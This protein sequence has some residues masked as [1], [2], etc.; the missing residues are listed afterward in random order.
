MQLTVGE[1]EQM[2]EQMQQTL[3]WLTD[4]LSLIPYDQPTLGFQKP[5]SPVS[6]PVGD[7]WTADGGY[8]GGLD[9]TTK[10]SD[11]DCVSD[12]YER[13]CKIWGFFL[14]WS[15]TIQ[16]MIVCESG[17]PTSQLPTLGLSMQWLKLPYW[18]KDYTRIGIADGTPKV[19]PNNA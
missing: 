2:E 17:F 3:R 16:Q 13:K 7:T 14:R 11:Y 1:P 15:T 10:A 12:I 9:D 19:M 18:G 8:G 5:S 4:M 6:H